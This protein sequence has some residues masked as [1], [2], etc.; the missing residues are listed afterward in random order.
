MQYPAKHLSMSQFG[1]YRR[2]GQQY[3][4]RYV[5]GIISPPGFA[6]LRGKNFHK[7]RD[8]QL[9]HKL[10]HSTLPPEQDALDHAR[11][12]SVES[13]EQE[14]IDFEGIE[15]KKFRDTLIDSSIVLTRLDRAAY[16]GEIMPKYV[17]EQITLEISELSVPVIGY[18]DCFTT[19]GALD[20]AKTSGSYSP[21]KANDSLA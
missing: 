14:E 2:C 7:T 21:P 8:F 4:L 19:D 1:M 3:F 20:D 16:L 6:L 18:V 9:T 13:I 11:D 15:K 5:E 12:V 17:E 10:E